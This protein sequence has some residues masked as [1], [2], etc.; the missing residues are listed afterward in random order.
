MTRR[1]ARA[2]AIAVVLSAAS[3]AT[4]DEAQIQPLPA[5]AIQ[6]TQMYPGVQVYQEQGKVRVIY[7]KP[8]TWGATADDAAAQWLTLHSGAFGVGPVTLNQKWSTTIQ[9][10]RFTSYAYQQSIDGMPVEFGN[11]RVLVLNGAV[12]RVVY[13]AGTLAK[14]PEGGFG[15]AGVTGAQALASVRAVRAYADL[16][17]WSNPQLIV[18]QGEGDWSAPVMAWKFTGEH[19]DVNRARRLT[20]FIDAAN[21][22]ALFIRNEVI[23]TDVIGNVSGIGTPGV[24]PDIAT[25][26]PV[27]MP[28][29]EIR[30]TITGGNNAFSNVNGGFTIPHPGTTPVTVT[31]NLSSGRWVNVNPNGIAELTVAGLA[32]PGTPASFEF[33]TIPGGANSQTTAQVNAFIGTTLIHNYYKDRAPGFTGIDVVL[34]ANTGV[35][36]TCNAF[37]NGSSINFY[38]TGGG[39][40]NTAYSTVVAHEYGHFVVAQLGLAQGAFGEGFSDVS[41]IMLYDVG[42]VGQNFFTNGG[43]I[44]N[45]AA[46]NQQYPCSSGAIHTC[47]Q[48]VG[49]IWWE[50]LV[51]FKGVYG[52]ATGLDKTRSLQVAWSQITTGGSGLNS[53]HPATAIEVLTVDDNDGNLANGTPHYPQ[54]CNAFSQHNIQCPAVSLIGFQY[55][56]GQPT[57]VTPNQPTIIRVDVVPVSGTPVQNSGKIS[58]RINNGSYTTVSMN[59]IAANQYEGTLP[60][61]A[62][63]SKIDYYF[64][65]S[66]VEGG[67]VN[68]PANAPT[69]SFSTTS[70]TGTVVVFTDSFETDLGWSGV[71]PGDN[72]TTGRWNRMPPQ[73]TFNG[74]APVQAG[75]D[76][77]PAPGVNCWVTDGNAGAS[78]GAFDVDNG[79]T[80]L[81]SPVLDLSAHAAAKISYWRWYSNGTNGTQDDTFRI[82]VSNNNGSTWVPVETLGPSGP[83][84]TAGWRFASWRVSDYVTPTAQVRVRFIAE[85]IGGGSLVE[86]SVDDFEVSS[87]T[88]AVACYADCN[89][90]AILNLADFGCF[91]TNFA[92]GNMYADCNGDTILNLADFGCFQT[93]FAVG[94]P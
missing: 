88:C 34:P 46:A 41:A 22:N 58:Y 84:A 13:A 33:N 24:L 43:H 10:G 11:A 21:G 81:T 82:S 9:D 54:I 12:P 70:A 75:A 60:A 61:A 56:N 59:Q 38:N 27:S 5:E 36:G 80:T 87:F 23:H 83:E 77:T 51:N 29:P 15:D 14:R 44:R 65:A 1:L 85:D 74:T 28:M 72:A 40:N 79:F 71:G 53:A 20:F 93:K 52:S 26:P 42:I 73:A 17:Q 92:T 86:A 16:T 7:G 62:C 64:T 57:L 4:A 31:S 48:I 18:Y 2:F 90:D 50:T 63:Q 69:S 76:H 49:G 91:Q 94:C 68:D 39:C 37:F 25:N 47:G 8:M 32:T 66:S 45:P 55:P 3:A 19:P 30:M 67:P 35:A 89:G 78:V 6:L